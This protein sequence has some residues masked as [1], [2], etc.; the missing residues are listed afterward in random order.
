MSAEIS[1]CPTCM[2][3]STHWEGKNGE[4]LH[5]LAPEPEPFTGGLDL[6]PEQLSEMYP[7]YYGHQALDKE[8]ADC[9]MGCGFRVRNEDGTWACNNCRRIW[10]DPEGG[11]ICKLREIPV[12]FCECP[13]CVYEN[14]GQSQREVQM[15]Q[16]INME[17]WHNGGGVTLRI[18]NKYDPADKLPNVVSLDFADVDRLMALLQD[19]KAHPSPYCLT[20]ACEIHGNG[21]ASNTADRGRTDFLVNVVVTAVEG[22]VGYWAELREYKWSEDENR[23]MTGASVEVD[24]QDGK[25]W[26]TVNL[27]TIREGLAKIK[28][29][30]F[31]INPAVLSAILMGDRNNDAGEIDSEAADCIIQAGLF[32]EL[33]YG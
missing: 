18:K 21:N 32:G 26:R 31:Q 10:T 17:K 16:V 28:E 8:A 25:G 19:Y 12:R 5:G 3:P 27:D 30:S 4:C 1:F 33:V 9:P 15:S 6:T 13:H 7:E 22:G 20:E 2:R 29:S 14:G 23:Y 11:Y 24:A